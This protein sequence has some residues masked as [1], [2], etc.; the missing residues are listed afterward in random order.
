MG[1]RLADQE[2]NAAAVQEDPAQNPT[3]LFT[4]TSWLCEDL[5]KPEYSKEENK[6]VQQEGVKQSTERWRLLPDNR[7][8]VP[9]NLAHMA[10]LPWE[11]LLNRYYCIAHLL[12]LCAAV[13]NQCL[14]CAKNNPTQRLKPIPGVQ[15]VGSYPFEDIE[16]DVTE[17][18]PSKGKGFHSLYTV[19]MGQH[20][21]QRSSKPSPV[22]SRSS[23]NHTACRPQS[24]GKVEGINQ[25]LKVTLVK[26]CQE[27]QAFWVDM[28]SLALLQSRCTLGPTGYSPFKILFGRLPHLAKYGE[29]SD[30]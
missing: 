20:S 23:G 6:W 11:R 14:T 17:I 25:T 30:S 16:V 18:K 2:A 22:H 24:S 13:S 29:T 27:I 28:L 7:P 8:V 21:W 19:T 15:Q 3:H 4:V 9:K 26:L 10:R 12:K 5:G 1:N